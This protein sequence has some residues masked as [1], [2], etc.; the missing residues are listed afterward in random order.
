MSETEKI[1][2][3]MSVVDLGKIDLLVEDGHYSNRTDFIRTAIRHNLAAHASEIKSSTTRKTLV[4]GIS[5]YDHATLTKYYKD[6]EMLDIRIVGM[7]ILGEKISPELALAT[8]NSVK[9]LGVFKASTAV[10]TALAEA[11]R[12]L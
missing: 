6:G 3:N 5:G 1:T 2:I 4:I 9:V 7:V 11:G 8:I 10:K 12:I